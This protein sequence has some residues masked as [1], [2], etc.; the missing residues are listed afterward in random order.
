MTRSRNPQRGSAM[1]VT[2][3]IIG[4]LIAGGAVLVSLQI[5]SN[6]STDLTRSGM[7]ALYCAEAGLSAARPVVALN[8]T[9]PG[10]ATPDGWATALVASGTGTL[11]EPT[12]LYTAIGSHDLD[13]P[14]DGV[15]DF[16]VYLKDNGDES[17]GADDPT[18]DN[19]LQIFI[20]A[21]CKKYADTPK[22][23]EELVQFTGGGSCMPDQAGG[24]DG[25][26]NKNDGC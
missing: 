25:N 18:L 5:S 26:G 22:Q 12:W 13:Q 16:E 17:S 1:L 7:S 9:K 8:Y 24:Q 19:D 2:L 4:A 20:V 10:T 14:P 23:V 21:K 15:D 6:R 11:T 3:I